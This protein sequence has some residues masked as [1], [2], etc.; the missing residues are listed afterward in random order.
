MS[1]LFSQAPVFKCV[2]SQCIVNTV[3]T[4]VVHQ[5]YYVCLEGNFSHQTWD[6]VT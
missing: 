3:V 5:T 4:E 6:Y 1:M 2:K